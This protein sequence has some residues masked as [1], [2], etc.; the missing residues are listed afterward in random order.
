MA[1]ARA[2][3]LLKLEATQGIRMGIIDLTFEQ[4]FP[5]QSQHHAP[6]GRS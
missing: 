3:A 5:R 1:I 4:A 2:S 6:S